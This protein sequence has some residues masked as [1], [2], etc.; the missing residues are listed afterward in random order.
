M[1]LLLLAGGFGYRWCDAGS[2]RPQFRTLPVTRGDLFIGVTAT[3]R[4]NRCEIID[5]GAQIVGM[6]KSFGPDA[7]RPGKTI[8]F[9][10]RVREGDV[11]AALD[12]RSLRVELEKTAAGLR[13]AEAEVQQSQRATVT[14]RSAIFI[15]PSGCGIRIRRPNSRTPSRSTSIAKAELAMSEAKVEQAKSVKK[16]AEINLDYS[17]IRSPADGTMIARRVNVGQTVVAGLNAPSLFSWP[18]DLSRMQVWAEVNEADI[19]DVHV[20]Q[21][22]TVQGR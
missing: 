5:V 8:D 15:A 4:L 17:T 14:R 2:D 10:S 6:I 16:E 22:V 20:G 19:G 18:Q 1:C 11:L 12:D 9:N 13:M 21:K 7:G 3:G